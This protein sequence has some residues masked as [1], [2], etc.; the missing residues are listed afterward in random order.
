MEQKLQLAGATNSPVH[1]VIDEFGKGAPDEEWI[2]GIAS[3]HGCVIHCSTFEPS[4]E[5]RFSDTRTPGLTASSNFFLSTSGY[6]RG[7]NTSK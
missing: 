2:T 4:R 7:Q 3:E 6:D 5:V 1:S